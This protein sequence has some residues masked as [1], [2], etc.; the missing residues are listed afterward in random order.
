M[1]IAQLVSN[2]HQVSDK[3]NHA[4]Y[5]HVAWLCNGLVEKGHQIDLF[6]AGD[7]KTK[8]NLNSVYPKSFSNTKL[9]ENLVKNYTFLLNYKCYNKAK[10]FDIIHSHF[11]LINLFFSKLTD[12]PSIQSIHSPITDDQKEILKHFKSNRFISFSL[13]Q[14][15]SM[16]E[17]N[18]IANIYHGIDVDIFSFNPKPDDYFLYLG[19]ITKEKGVHYAIEAARAAKVPLILAGR[20]YPN[21]G[22]WH[23]KIEKQ[24]DGKN[25][26]YVGELN[27]KD[28][29]EYLK[30]ARGLLFPTQYNQE[31][32]GY[33]MIEAMACGTP[34]IG[35]NNGSVPEII[36]DQKTGYVVNDVAAMTQAIKNI[37]KIKREDVRKRAEIYFSVKKMVSGYEKIYQ[38]IIT[39]DKFNKNNKQ[40]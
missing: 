16:P 21:E 35:W 29:I 10:D 38:R 1:K 3:S 23:D 25:I 37:D 8:A 24:I 33:V 22:Y 27:F 20:S 34:V 19:R 32:F 30:K 12:T 17:L 11:T 26:K 4:I 39:E 9:N 2:I 6:A 31:V 18:W 36:S 13:A 40:H 14:R 15:R 7:S 28:K 5:S